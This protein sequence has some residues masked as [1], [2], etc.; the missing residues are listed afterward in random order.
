MAWHRVA[1]LQY[2]FARKQYT[3]QHNE[4]EYTEQNVHNNK[5]T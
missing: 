4:S 3:E 2:T 5:N 1:V